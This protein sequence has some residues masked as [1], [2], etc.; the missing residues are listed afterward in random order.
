[1]VLPICPDRLGK[2]I[3]RPFGKHRYDD[4]A[5][6]GRNVGWLLRCFLE[7]YFV[8]AFSGTSWGLLEGLLWSLL[9]VSGR[10]GHDGSPELSRRGSVDPS[11]GRL[12]WSWG[13]LGA[14]PRIPRAVLGP[15]RGRLGSSWGLLGAF[16]VQVHLGAL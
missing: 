7:A 12:G 10:L 2:T 15:S 9:W 5:S 6:R 14:V 13:P 8:G 11:W 4:V 16:Q 1:M 3:W